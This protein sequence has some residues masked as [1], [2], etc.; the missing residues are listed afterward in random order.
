MKVKSMEIPHIVK[1]PIYAGTS[2]INK[3]AAIMPGVTADQDISLFIP[4]TVAGADTIGNLCDKYVY[5]TLGS[6]AIGGTTY[7]L[8]EV[9]LHDAYKFV[10]IEYDKTDTLAVASVSGTTVTITSLTADIDGTW[11]YAVSG[12]G[13]G[14]LA[15]CVSTAAGS[16]VTKTATAWDSTTVLIKI[17]RLGHQLVKINTAADKIGSDAGDGS[18]TVAVLENWLERNGT[19]V[20]LDPTKHDNISDTNAK[21]FST[22]LVRNTFGHTID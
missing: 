14:L 17:M 22:I 4:T 15:Y 19:R 12:T 5:A 8:R 16:C 21:F 10:E 20:L 18:W 7:V 2:N 3:G 11:L 13:A 9:E 1:V 6:S